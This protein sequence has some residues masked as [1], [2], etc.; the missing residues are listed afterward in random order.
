MKME[1]AFT[2]KTALASRVGSV[3]TE[4]NCLGL[5]I[6]PKISP[7]NSKSGSS[8]SVAAHTVRMW[9]SVYQDMPFRTGMVYRGGCACGRYAK[10]DRLGS[11]DGVGFDRKC[12]V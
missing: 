5:M 4:S 12:T 2:C 1:P 10:A 9:L 6:A 3:Y 7:S 8:R 11:W